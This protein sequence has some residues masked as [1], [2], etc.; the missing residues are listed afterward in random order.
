MSV[1]FILM[2]DG[3]IKGSGYCSTCPKRI[4]DKECKGKHR[5]RERGIRETT[6]LFIKKLKYALRKGCGCACK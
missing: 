3:L 2:L 4:L 1:L 6:K 5:E